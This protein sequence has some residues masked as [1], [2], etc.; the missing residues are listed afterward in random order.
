M[1]FITKNIYI[2][3]FVFYIPLFSTHKETKGKLK[4]INVKQC[5]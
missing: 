2:P 5:V 4:D 3:S 1:C